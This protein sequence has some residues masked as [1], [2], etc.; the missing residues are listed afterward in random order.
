MALAFKNLLHQYDEVSGTW[1]PVTTD[2]F[3]PQNS[4]ESTSAPL[5]TND[6]SEGF[7][8][9]SQWVDTTADEAYICVD[10]SVGAAVWENITLT[11]DDLTDYLLLDGTRSMDGDLNMDGYNLERVRYLSG[12]S[13]STVFE[14]DYPF[15]GN[16][17]AYSSLHASSDLYVGSYLYTNYIYANGNSQVYFTDEIYCSGGIEVGNPI[18]MYS[19]S[20]QFGGSGNASINSGGSGM[21]LD[22]SGADMTLFCDSSYNVAIYNGKLDF[23]QGNFLID[24]SSSDV[25]LSTANKINL[26]PSSGMQI[27]GTNCVSNF[28]GA[29]TSI[30]VTNGLVTAIS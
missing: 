20:L 30:T 21:T 23:Y 24:A 22:C 28:T 8:V 27:N 17:Y 18:E 11:A 2:D 4:Y 5:A 19:N 3:G 13:G 14:L 7:G 29:V 16:A 9:G 25:S 12:P 6:S 10:A 26:D 15:S 1:V